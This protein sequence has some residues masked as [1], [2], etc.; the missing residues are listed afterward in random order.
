MK[1]DG[2]HAVS[3]SAFTRFSTLFSTFPQSFPRYPRLGAW[4]T[5]PSPIFLSFFIESTIL[6]FFY[7]TITICSTIL[8]RLVEKL[9]TVQT[10]RITGY[11]GHNH[12]FFGPSALFAVLIAPLVCVQIS[13]RDRKNRRRRAGQGTLRPIQRILA[14]GQQRLQP[15]LRLQQADGVVKGAVVCGFVR[16]VPCTPSR[17]RSGIRPRSASRLPGTRSPPP[18][19]PPGGRRGRW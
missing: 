17:P 1:R 8:I 4:E 18:A 12:R 14:D 9:F 7:S 10:V 6:I 13:P 11:L 16:R 2:G 15:L 3:F 5:G 19:P